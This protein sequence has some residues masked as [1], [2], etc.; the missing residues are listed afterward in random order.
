MPE[1]YRP[2]LTVSPSVLSLQ[3]QMLLPDSGLLILPASLVAA[4]TAFFA[5]ATVDVFSII[6]LFL[7][8]RLCSLVLLALLQS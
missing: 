3:D 8:V 6:E 4:L 5:A 2:V 1:Q 7:L